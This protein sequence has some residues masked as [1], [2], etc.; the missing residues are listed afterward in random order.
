[1]AR[2]K[3]QSNIQ[4]FHQMRKFLSLAVAITSIFAASGAHAALILIDDFNSAPQH[5]YDIVNSNLTPGVST[6]ASLSGSSTPLLASD[7]RLTNSVTNL[8]GN[9]LS[10]NTTGAISSIATDSPLALNML[11]VT[12]MGGVNSTN[13]VTWTVGP[14]AGTASSLL[15]DVLGAYTSNTKL[16]FSIGNSI[17]TDQ[18]VGS[19]TPNGT[20]IETI[21]ITPG[22]AR[23][24]STGGTLA[25][26]IT[27]EDGYDLSLDN[28]RL[29][30]SSSAT[31]PEPTS[32]ALVGLALVGAGFAASRRKA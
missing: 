15:F 11:N 31:I 2:S 32:L 30:T 6:T 23:A 26:T 1:V 3:T 28:V 18:L 14:L 12:N 9:A 21:A 24:F 16:T 20:R 7:R 10:G 8:N 13:T 29:T 27:G 17:F 5:A 4:E 19:G 22:N 25:L